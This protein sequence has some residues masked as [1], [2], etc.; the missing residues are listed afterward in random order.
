MKLLVALISCLFFLHAEAVCPELEGTYN[1]HSSTGKQ[2]GEV[3]QTVENG[4]ITYH[5]KMSDGQEFSYVA[6]GKVRIC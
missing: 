2:K 5:F 4:V 1:C 3:T 6:D